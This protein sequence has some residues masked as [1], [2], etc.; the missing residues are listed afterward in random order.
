MVARAIGRELLGAVDNGFNSKDHTELVV[1]L[2]PIGLH[3]VLDTGSEP[4][5]LLVVGVHFAIKA[6]IPLAAE[7]A[8]NILW[9]KR[10]HRMIQKRTVQMGQR[11]ATREQ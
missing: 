4:A 7:K 9:G 1:H 3:A 2:E 6:A 11:R 10:A 5:I 8:Q